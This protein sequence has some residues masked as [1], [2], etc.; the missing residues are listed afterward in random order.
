MGSM[1]TSLIYDLKTRM[2]VYML[3]L[4]QCETPYK[5]G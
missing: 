3:Q 2:A 1:H 5:N 4:W